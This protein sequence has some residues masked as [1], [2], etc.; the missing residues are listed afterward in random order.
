MKRI[1]VVI[2]LLTIVSSCYLNAQLFTGGSIGLSTSGGKQDYGA[3]EQDK[4]SYMN[5]DFSPMVGYFLSDNL[6]AGLKIQLSMDKTT[7]PPFTE[8]GD[9]TV[10]TETEIGFVPFVRY[11]AVTFDKFS[12]FGQVQAGVTMGTEKTKTGSTEVEGPK[13]T[14][15]LFNVLPAVAFEASDHLMLE[16]Y[17]NLFRFGFTAETEKE[18]NNKETT[19][20]FNFGLSTNNIFTT[21]AVSVGAIYKF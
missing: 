15:I 20:S 6:A 4:T 1:P 9:E 2:L 21:G 19:N 13:T 12:L 16:A 11:Y 18:G 7:T 8:G 3:G 5:L 17:I 10:N 14:T